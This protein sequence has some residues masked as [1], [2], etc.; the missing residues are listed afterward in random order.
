VVDCGFC[1]EQDEEIAYDTY[2]PRRNGATLATLRAADVVIAV[3]GA[4]PVGL[5]RLIRLLPDLRA[6]APRAEVRVVVNQVRRGPVGRNHERRLLE[7]LERYA[8]VGS[9]VLVPADRDAVDASLACGR[10]L[11]EVAPSSAAR[12]AVLELAV[13]LVS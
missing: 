10:T 3:G 5:Q 6:A 13:A 2:V 11:A 1:L 7:S 4:D 12:A 8:G 9:A